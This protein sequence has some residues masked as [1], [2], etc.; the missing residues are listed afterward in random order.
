MLNLF[1][2]L[3]IGCVLIAALVFGLV[4]TAR[5]ALA[6][7]GLA[8]VAWAMVGAVLLIEALTVYFVLRPV[9]MVAKDARRIA[10]GNLEHRVEWSGRD[11]FGL[12]A[13][14]LNRLAVRLR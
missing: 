9:R 6:L 8:G 4:V 5:H 7:A 1:Q 14:E 12:I 10:Q 2:R 11:D 13:A 3:I